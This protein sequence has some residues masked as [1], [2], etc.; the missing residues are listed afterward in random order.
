MLT[1]RLLGV[2]R[3]DFRAD[4]LVFDAEDPVFGGGTCRVTGCRRTARSRG[5]CQG[6]HLRWVKQGRPDL[7]TFAADTDP[8]WRRQRPNAHCRVP[9]CGYGVARTGLCQLHFQRWDRAHRPDLPRW[10]ADPPAI[11]QPAP[12]AVCRIEHCPLWPHADGPFCRPHANTWRVRG[13]PDVE[14]FVRRFVEVTATEDEIIRLDRLGPGLRL[15][16]GYALQRRRDQPTTKTRPAV[17]MALVRALVSTGAASLLDRSEDEWRTQIGRLAPKDGQLRALLFYARR[18]VEDLVDAGG[19]EAEFDR[20]VW[21]MRRLGFD[22]NQRLDFTSIAAPWL[23]PLVK[24][25]LRWRLSSGL[26]LAAASR[27]LLALTRFAAFCERAG[28]TSLVA[29]DRGV[30]ERYLADLHAELAGRQRHG[31]QIGQLNSFLHAVRQHRWDDSLPA[32]ALI[33]S[34]DYPTRTERP[35]RALAE[36]VMA[37]VEHPDNLARFPDPA[38]RLVTV[39]L[40]RTGLRISDALRLPHDCVVPD[41]DGAPYLRYL[42][43]KMKRQALVPI[44]EE[45][46]ALIAE[47][48]VRVAD[49]PVLFPRPTKNPDRSA[50]IAASTY[51]L[52]LYRWLESCEVRDAHGRP[53]HLTPHQ[54]RHTLGT[55]LINRDVPQE[56]VRR[57]LDH[58]SPQMTAHY[59]RLH[60]STVRRHWEAARKVDITGQTVLVD[61]DGPLAEA[62]WA[63]QRLG[64]VT[65]ALPNG[66]CGL[67]VQKSCPHANAC[68]TCPMFVTTTEFL[69]QHR[70][71]R[72]QVLQILTAAEA[73]GQA[74]LVETNQQ[75]LGSLDRII[76]AL[77]D[78]PQAGAEG[79]APAGQQVADAG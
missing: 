39:I 76:T 63:K 5:M 27:G 6:H 52:A 35:P 22:G 51:R 13:R 55:R 14:D 20:D 10:L 47:Q 33:F 21:Q 24:R 30:L 34:E 53:V 16:I 72:Q 45:L 31:D 15:E 32:G 11:K 70:S 79:S 74:G 77:D 48:Q 69:P 37:Q 75:V 42:N 2:V 25:W 43:H 17:V 59:A 44:D 65:Q 8:Q 61:P 26:G 46:H 54:W 19:W 29:I 62:A 58:D 18:Q 28:I 23:R 71:H 40:I 64:R 73:R 36:Q 49:A 1:E 3:P 67:P 9:G 66:F 56:V 38:H 78:D 4:V 7:A 12:G 57:I 41:A 60:D 68:L 50:P